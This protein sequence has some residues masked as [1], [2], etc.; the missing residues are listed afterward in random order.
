MQNMKI[1]V[2]YLILPVLQ[3]VVVTDHHLCETKNIQSYTNIYSNN[4][5]KLKLPANNVQFSIHIKKYVHSIHGTS[6]VF[7]I[8]S[9]YSGPM[10]FC[11]KWKMMG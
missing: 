2:A 7:K 3:N 4:I 6:F 5:Q 11:D 8:F 9:F 10:V 1:L